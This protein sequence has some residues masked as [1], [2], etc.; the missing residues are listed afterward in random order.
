MAVGGSGGTN[1][2][3]VVSNLLRSPEKR[4]FVSV[5]QQTGNVIGKCKGKCIK[6]T[7]SVTSSLSVG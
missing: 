6:N 4:H 1:F 7:V 3:G 5:Q 2:P